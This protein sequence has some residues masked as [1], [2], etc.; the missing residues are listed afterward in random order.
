MAKAK[1]AACA[2]A[3]L[4]RVTTP[5]AGVDGRELT[6]DGAVRRVNNK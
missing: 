5:E 4:R 3:A 2:A 1:N 6:V